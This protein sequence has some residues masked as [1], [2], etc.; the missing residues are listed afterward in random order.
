MLCAESAMQIRHRARDILSAEFG[1]GCCIIS[2]DS[3]TSQCGGYQS[4]R[5][6][7]TARKKVQ[8]YTGEY[9][10]YMLCRDMNVL[11]TIV[12]YYLVKGKKPGKRQNIKWVNMKY[13]GW[14]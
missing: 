3:R 1:E 10:E 9:P 11:N 8:L 6:G 4:Y 7:E 2:H 5:S 12:S 14:E 13:P